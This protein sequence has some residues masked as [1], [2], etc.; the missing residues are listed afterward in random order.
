MYS[1][2]D[3]LRQCSLVGKLIIVFS[4]P[5]LLASLVMRSLPGTSVPVLHAILYVAKLA[6]NSS[7]NC[8]AMPLPITPTVLTVL[9]RASAAEVIMLPFVKY[10]MGKSIVFWCL[11]VQGFLC[12]LV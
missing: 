5:A 11:R 7:L 6:G 10:I 3:G 1:Y 12:Q 2:L 4:M 9:T 8:K